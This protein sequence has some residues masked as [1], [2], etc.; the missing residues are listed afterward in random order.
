MCKTYKMF[1]LGFF[2]IVGSFV[3]IVF[4]DIFHSELILELCGAGIFIGLVVYI[5]AM[6]D[7]V[8]F[9][10]RNNPYESV[11]MWVLLTLCLPLIGVVYSFFKMRAIAK[12]QNW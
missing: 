1:K 3:S 2:L 11:R 5:L 6:R 4:S 10:A 9:L 8:L 12:Q 7:L